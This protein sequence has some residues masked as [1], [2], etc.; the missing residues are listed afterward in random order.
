VQRGEDDLETPEKPVRPKAMAVAAR[1]ERKLHR[2]S[3]QN[4]TATP[5]AAT[6]AMNGRSLAR[7]SPV[8][9][10]VLAAAMASDTFPQ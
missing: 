4:K 5:A 10:V 6:G 2:N 9:M 7:A 8:M 3:A 1:G